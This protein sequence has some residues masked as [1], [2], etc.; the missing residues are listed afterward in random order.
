MNRSVALIG[1]LA[2]LLQVLSTAGCTHQLATMPSSELP[3]STNDAEFGPGDV[4]EVRV[5]GEEKLS[6]K[7]QVGSEGAIRFPF[8]GVVEVGGKDSD[9]VATLIREGLIAREIM[10]DP[11]VSVFVVESNSR[12]IS[13]LGAVAKPGTL[14]IVPGITVVQAVSTAGGF[15]PLASKDDTVVTRRVNGKLE[16]YRIAVSDVSRGVKEDFPLRA[17]DIVF[18]PERVF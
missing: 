9:A 8:L 10:R 17:G 7:Y 12:R 13:V 11:H 4:F 5:F 18:V 1:A 15:T 14:P 6:G 3:V 16:R 2:W